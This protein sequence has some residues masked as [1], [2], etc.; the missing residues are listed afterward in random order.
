MIN[1]NLNQ[2]GINETWESP[3][4]SA[5]GGGNLQK[6]WRHGEEGAFHEAVWVHVEGGM[7]AAWGS[8]PGPTAPWLWAT[9]GQPV[10]HLPQTPAPLQMAQGEVLRT[11]GRAQR[12]DGNVTPDLP[13]K[14]YT[15][16]GCDL[17]DN[18]QQQDPV[19]QTISLVL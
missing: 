11:T 12:H 1:I 8:T 18:K 2:W 16:Q 9:A 3:L 4:F 19:F 5:A 17:Q 6:A 10:S 14:R 7:R 13:V 15:R